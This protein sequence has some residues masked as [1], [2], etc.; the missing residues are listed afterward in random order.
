M[1]SNSTMISMMTTMT[2]ILTEVLTSNLS[3]KREVL[4]KEEQNK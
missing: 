4:H 3:V 2:L 1:I